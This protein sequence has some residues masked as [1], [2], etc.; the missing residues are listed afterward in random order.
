MVLGA[1]RRRRS[2][3]LERSNAESS[4]PPVRT[5]SRLAFF[6]R[7]ESSGSSNTD[8]MTE[9]AAA[10]KVQSIFRGLKTRKESAR[11]R[12]SAVAIQAQ[13]RGK[14]LRKQICTTGRDLLGLAEGSF[15]YHKKDVEDPTP[16]PNWFTPEAGWARHLLQKQDGWFEPP[17][18]LIPTAKEA[19]L[20]LFDRADA[21]GELRV[22]VLE[23]A[24]LKNMDFLSRSDPYALILFE[25]FAGRTNAWRGTSRPRW[26][27][28]CPRA[29]CFPIRSAY[30]KVY[31]GVKDAD[32]RTAD[33][34]VGRVVLE[35]ASLIE[36]TVYDC[37]LPLT[38]Y[39]INRPGKVGEIRL[40]YSVRFISDRRRLLRYVV[41]LSAPTFYI[42]FVDKEAMDN[43]R[44]VLLGKKAERG[45][46][47][48]VLKQYYVEIISAIND[49]R[50]DLKQSMIA[51]FF[52][53][54]PSA[55]AISLV[56]LAWWQLLISYPQFVPASVPLFM[57]VHLLDRYW[58]REVSKY[59]IHKQLSFT[60]LLS[61]LFLPSA[62]PRGPLCAQPVH[63]ASVDELTAQENSNEWWNT[64]AVTVERKTLEGA[65]LSKSQKRKTAT[66][67]SLAATLK[68]AGTAVEETTTEWLA[69]IAR[70]WDDD[71]HI[72]H[73]GPE[74]IKLS[75][76]LDQYALEVAEVQEGS[77]ALRNDQ[78]F[79]VPTVKSYNPLATYL[80]PV[81]YYLGEALIPLRSLRRLM[82]W[83][84]RILTFWLC[85]MLFM[86]TII[87]AI[88]PWAS[89]I[90]V[91][92]RLLGI[93][94][95]GPHM[96]FVGR[97]YQQQVAED[98]RAEK[99]FQDL[100]EDGK[101]ALLRK[102]R[103][104]LAQEHKKRLDS[105][106]SSLNRELEDYLR[107]NQYTMAIDNT[108]GS[109]RLK[110][111]ALADPHRSRAYPL[112][113]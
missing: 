10:Q 93:L 60:R 98:E 51:L 107:A 66:P 76:I 104:R 97:H 100:D 56:S 4:P 49:S 73:T 63:K 64:Y 109:S 61:M 102:H 79:Q 106:R 48:K 108:R 57:L 112:V 2:S 69:S 92:F 62:I 91:S 71:A 72:D 34:N 68:V 23:A 105:M 16:S 41:P 85:C 17:T 38:C 44:F 89:V 95:F 36:R 54:S 28:T 67:S 86:A 26:G 39:N 58:K 43:A 80:A 74:E 94:L 5:H 113:E 110:Y 59:A 99:E 32:D 29:F 55:A 75:S 84:D 7:R 103:T 111:R 13:L 6:S 21:I 18:N 27:P 46:S 12:A 47:S 82:N 30:S 77:V 22:E 14:R 78:G 11:Q 19:P 3:L 9:D 81:Q 31:I 65:G 96:Y 33:D 25:S 35:L 45:Y 101:V 37:W 88:I 1:L 8:A 50:E 40:R 90:V 24:R 87:L 53:D 52:W 20:H 70:Q 15:V 42:P 83:H